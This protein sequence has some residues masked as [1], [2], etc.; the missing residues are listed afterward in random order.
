MPDTY[1]WDGYEYVGVFGNQCYYLGPGNVWLPMV[2]TRLA[3][4][5]TWEMDH[6]AWRMHAT[7][8]ERYRLDALGHVH[9]WHAGMM[10]TPGTEH[11]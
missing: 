4:F 6:H 1:T 7:R 9:P 5:H 11:K 10:P 3:R 8:N 2:G